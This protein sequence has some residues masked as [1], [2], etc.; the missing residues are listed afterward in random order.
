MMLMVK[1]VMS[2]N[3]NK[4]V[5]R[6]LREVID[7]WKSADRR[8]KFESRGFAGFMKSPIFEGEVLMRFHSAI[9]DFYEDDKYSEPIL[10][11]YNSRAFQKMNLSVENPETDVIRLKTFLDKFTQGGGNVKMLKRSLQ[12]LTGYIQV[13]L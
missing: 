6:C 4:N 13:S 7:E 3:I 1:K 12:L 10:L 5:G 9:D 11:N 2:M 8:Y